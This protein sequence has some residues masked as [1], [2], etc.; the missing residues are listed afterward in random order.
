M[1]LRATSCIGKALRRLAGAQILG[2]PIIGAAV[3]GAVVVTPVSAETLADALI[4]AYR[5]SHLLEQNRATLRAA[6]EDVAQAVAALR[7]VLEWAAGYD[8]GKSYLYAGLPRDRQTASAQLQASV[9]LF[10]FGRRRMNVDMKRESVL[11]TREA[12]RMVEQQVLLSAVQAYVDVRGTAAQVAI[13]RDSLRACTE[14]VTATRAR[15]AVGDVTRTDLAQAEAAE[16]EARAGLVAAEG[17]HRLAR[18]AYRAAVGRLPGT[19][20]PVPKLPGLPK[21]LDA[22]RQTALRNNPAVRQAQHMLAVSEMG[23]DAAAADRRPTLSASAGFLNYEGGQ[24]TTRAGIALS[25]T[26]YSGGQKSSLHRQ[27]LAGRDAA[28]AALQQTGVT[29]AEDVAQV[30]TRIEVYRSQ[31]GAYDDQVRA[32]EAAWA[33]VREEAKLGARTTLD[34]LDAE[35]TLLR[36]RSDRIAA[37][38]SL[39]VAYYQLL[40][41]MGLLTAE[42]LKLGIPTYDPAAYYNA[43]QNAPYTSSRGQSLDRVLRAIGK[44][45]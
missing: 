37:G 25:Q 10:D 6:D 4:S 41:T 32:A 44:K 34:V 27:A 19:L 22:A 16:A 18:E 5:Q 42:D 35:Q 40:S 23:I 3:A 33:G 11:G 9:T 20:A 13:N 1:W 43:V 17:D 39:E 30:W 15:L 14:V 7:P 38:A 21:S 8:Y 29:L 2:A 36:A 31:T 26:L 24:Q 12:L 45:E 28:R